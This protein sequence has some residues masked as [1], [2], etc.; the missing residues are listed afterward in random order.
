[1]MHAKWRSGATCSEESH[2]ALKRDARRWAAEVDCIGEIDLGDGLVVVLGN[3]RRCQ[4]TLA[5]E[6]VVGGFQVSVGNAKTR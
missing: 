2:A 3:C 5:V 6:R 1:M 4:S